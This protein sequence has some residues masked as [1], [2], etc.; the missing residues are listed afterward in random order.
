VP[1][2]SSG[3]CTTSLGALLLHRYIFNHA[4]SMQLSLCEVNVRNFDKKDGE[5][6]EEE[7]GGGGGS[8][9]CSHVSHRSANINTCRLVVCHC[10][11]IYLPMAASFFLLAP[12]SPPF[13][14]PSLSADRNPFSPM[15]YFERAEGWMP[16]V[17]EC[18]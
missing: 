10:V 14:F 15:R 13:L 3:H 9:H 11:T 12:A 5:E 1:E 4:P 8:S 6:E 17:P 16:R 7:E 18:I 2:K